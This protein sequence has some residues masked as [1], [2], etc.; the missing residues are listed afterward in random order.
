MPVRARVLYII[1]GVYSDRFGQPLSGIRHA[2]DRSDHD[3]MKPPPSAASAKR[4]LPKPSILPQKNISSKI[5]RHIKNTTLH[6]DRA[7]GNK[8]VHQSRESIWFT[9]VY[10]LGSS[11]PVMLLHEQKPYRSSSLSEDKAFAYVFVLVLFQT[12]STQL[13]TSKTN[14]HQKQIIRGT[15]PPVL[16]PRTYYTVLGL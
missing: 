14:C 9:V 1:D 5:L 11:T 12:K 7:L 4:L 2:S 3:R 8:N 16:A 13:P 10:S 6:I 15:W